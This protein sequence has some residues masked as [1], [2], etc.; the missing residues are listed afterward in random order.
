MNFTFL[1]VSILITFCVLIC[2]E[3]AG[4]TTTKPGEAHLAPVKLPEFTVPKLKPDQVNI[5]LPGAFS[6]VV[7]GGGGRYFIFHIKEKQ[8]LAIYDVCEVKIVKLLPLS[9]ND[10]T[11]AA[12]ADKLVIASR[13]RKTIERYSLLTFRKELTQKLT[14]SLNVSHITMGAASNGPILLGLEHATKDAWQ[15][16]DLET[17]GP[18]AVQPG[19]DWK[20]GDAGNCMA[21]ASAD[22]RVFGVS[23]SRTTPAEIMV[24]IIKGN[25]IESRYKKESRG[26]VYPSS[27]GRWLFSDSGVYNTSLEKV[28]Q[29]RSLETYIPARFSDFYFKSSF[30]GNSFSAYVPTGKNNLFNVAGMGPEFQP[31][32]RRTRGPQPYP[33]F[34]RHFYIQPAQMML[35]LPETNDS[36]DLQSLDIIEKL[37]QNK[38]LH[39]YHFQA[40]EKQAFRG[41]TYEGVIKVKSLYGEVRYRL[42][43]PPQGMTISPEGVIR[44]KVPENFGVSASSAVGKLEIGISLEDESG[45]DM[46]FLLELEVRDK[47]DSPENPQQPGNAPADDSHQGIV[48][49]PPITPP[50]FEGKQLEVMLPRPYALVAPGGG[51]RYL[52]FYLPEIQQLALF[53]LSAAKLVKYLT[54]ESNSFA[55]CVGADKL[56]ILYLQDRMIHRYHIPTLEKEY[57]RRLSVEGT[58]VDISMDPASNGPI[59]VETRQQQRIGA[60][61]ESFV[62][63][64]YLDLQSLE[65]IPIEEKADPAKLFPKEPERFSLNQDLKET[66][67][68]IHLAGDSKPLVTVPD[69]WTTKERGY[70]SMKDQ[71]GFS[72]FHFIPEAD[73]LIDLT[74]SNNQR[75]FYLHR[76]NF[77]QELKK[78]EWDY[79]FALSRPVKYAERGARYQ[80]TVD[81][82]A[83]NGPLKYQ[84]DSG[85]AGMTVSS[86]GTIEWE[87]PADFGEN[88]VNVIASITDRSNQKIYQSYQIQLR[89]KDAAAAPATKQ[90]EAP[91]LLTKMDPQ[92]EKERLNRPEVTLPP[93]EPVQIEGNQKQVTLPAEIT[94]LVVGGG[95]RYLILYF[96]KVHQLGIFDITSTELVK[97][98][99][100]ENEDVVFTAGIEDLMIAYPGK[101]VLER[102]SLKT[103]Q[104]EAAVTLPFEEPLEG[105]MMGHASRGP[106][107]LVV[108]SS[109]PY[110]FVDPVSMQGMQLEFLEFQLDPRI[111]RNSSVARALRSQMVMPIQNAR[112]YQRFIETDRI[113]ADGR[114]AVVSEGI[115]K[116]TPSSIETFRPEGI[117]SDPIPNPAGTRLYTN[118][119]IHHSAVDPTRISKR[120]ATRFPAVRPG[121]FLEVGEKRDKRNQTIKVLTLKIEGEDNPEFPLNEIDY[122]LSISRA[123]NPIPLEKRFICLPDMNLLVQIPDTRDTL[124]L[125]QIELS[126]LLNESGEDY[127]YLTSLYPP[128]GRL[129]TLW[130]HQ[131]SVQ[132][133]QDVT[134]QLAKAP[135]GMKVS[136]SGLLTWKIP[137]D[138][139]TLHA[140]VGV[141]L[142]SQSGRELAH[143]FTITIPEVY[144]N[145]RR[146]EE[147]AAKQKAAEAKAQRDQE[148]AMAAKAVEE[149]HAS[150]NRLRVIKLKKEGPAAKDK[151]EKEAKLWL[152]R[153]QE[154]QGTQTIPYRIWTDAGGNRIEGQLV[155]VFGGIVK[156]RLKSD[157]QNGLRSR[158]SRQKPELMSFTLSELSL[159][160]QMY[161]KEY[162]AALREKRE[163]PIT[164]DEKQ[165][166]LMMQLKMIATSL[167]SK[168]ES[169]FGFPP[170]YSADRFESG[171]L[172]D[173]P[174]LS[175]RVHL[176]PYLGGAELYNLFRQDEPWD[177]D[178]N[179][180]F[181]PLM[182][183]YY[184]TPGSRA[185]RGKTNLLGVKGKDCI[186]FGKDEVRVRNVTD[187]PSNTAMVVVV[188]DELAIEWTRPDDWE[189]TSADDI[190]DLFRAGADLFWTIF[191]DGS[192][193]AISN[194]N[195]LDEISPIFTIRDGQP[196]NLK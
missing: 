4:Q 103:F 2:C 8:Q 166:E 67:M 182:P 160:D 26:A 60:R 106:L 115:L 101:K 146:K 50:S 74:Q 46:T 70:R 165:N 19:K 16:L 91:P 51:G 118:K 43:R 78:S 114:L 162:S 6:D 9:S 142:K 173:R 138:Y 153:Q 161:V 124:L 75:S 169:S 186:F 123:K 14:G 82:R 93:L 7:A 5:K 195:T 120:S 187:G 111:D 1:R 83:K 97:I 108:K 31:G 48:S 99:P 52:V 33:G 147:L 170:A 47:P 190:K 11:Y 90:F 85:P 174:M 20:L 167:K 143:N 127:L 15:I 96:E 37:K 92:S 56:V 135:E 164:A 121:C 65:P 100:V 17:L 175:W 86:S 163:R 68:Y 42:N 105:M 185:G 171:V 18:S 141:Q 95:G 145:N 27:D 88:Q 151:L 196:V 122:S 128:S 176:L 158:N 183:S 139:D 155:R 117:G 119:G 23:H 58:L 36:I 140:E 104:R 29:D 53:D 44:W 149:S 71:S 109:E 72:R 130:K 159:T 62:V 177:S 188:P 32:R 172:R 129:G 25:E 81:A 194:K 35:Y 126:K 80:Y 136:S 28:D 40:P 193:R 191:A 57:S 116:L 112:I 45:K 87:V 13:D 77:D 73:T 178:Y 192:V 133:R 107:L 49:L 157:S 189:Y 10:I 181:I 110:F 132:S 84:I 150:D 12:G 134:Y 39:I 21:Y 30:M 148:I 179:K 168:T 144:S 79:L 41:E 137:D 3:V 69:V 24:L 154:K 22:G 98:L 180:R 125:H 102:W 113:S 61:D 55:F 184:Q 89:G 76:V 94:N 152:Q 66:A 131:L 38:S 63:K 34:A 54:L 64:K 59:L 156:V